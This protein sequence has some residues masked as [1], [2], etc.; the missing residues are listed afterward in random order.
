MDVGM[1]VLLQQH[2]LYY[3]D[4]ACYRATRHANVWYQ[5]LSTIA[6]H[7]TEDMVELLEGRVSLALNALLPIERLKLPVLQPIRQTRDT[8]VDKG[9]R[10]G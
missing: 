2:S 10:H 1:G 4:C 7:L 8:A 5:M 6:A 3:P 9:I